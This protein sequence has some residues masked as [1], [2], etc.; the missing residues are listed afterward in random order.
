MFVVQI[1]IEDLCKELPE[2]V[3]VLHPFNPRTWEVE[4]AGG[5]LGF[6]A[7]QV[8]TGLSGLHN[9]EALSENKKV[10]WVAMAVHACDPSTWEQK[11][12]CHHVDQ[13]R[14]V[15]RSGFNLYIRVL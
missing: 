11:R 5:F 2:L 9:R 8:Y 12:L 6:K 13:P 10:M 7:S 14:L 3:T 4:E 15:K 1:F